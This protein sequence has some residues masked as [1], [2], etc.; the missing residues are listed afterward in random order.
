MIFEVCE[1]V[2][3]TPLPFTSIPLVFDPVPEKT[4]LV[5]HALPESA[6]VDRVSDPESILMAGLFDGAAKVTTDDVP[7]LTPNVIFLLTTTVSVYV[8]DCIIT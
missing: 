6:G 4:R 2:Y 5:A 7:P 1:S 3:E 8:P